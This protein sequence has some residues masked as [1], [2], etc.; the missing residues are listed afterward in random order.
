[1]PFLVADL[2]HSTFSSSK[3]LFTISTC[4]LK[5]LFSVALMLAKM[6]FAC[7]LNH[8]FGLCEKKRCLI[9]MKT[10]LVRK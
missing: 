7:V 4:C 10:V 6:N 1:M 8:S 2:F 5:T 9:S 3:I